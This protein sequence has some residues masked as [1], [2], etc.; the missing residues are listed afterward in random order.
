MLV[1]IIL[2]IIW[3]LLNGSLTILTL[4]SGLAVAMVSLL[5]TRRFINPDKTENV[6]FYKLILYPLFLIV[7]VYLAGFMVI[8]MIIMGCRTD[9]VKVETKLENDFLRTILCNSITLIPG[10]VMLEQEGAE[11]TVMLL[12]EENAGPING[13]MGAEVK[14]K[15]EALLLR[16]LKN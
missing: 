8:K 6:S 7:Q 10:S 15:P 1:I 13:D 16:A 12:R 4:I 14:G 11:L 9:V 3:L 2:A 5:F